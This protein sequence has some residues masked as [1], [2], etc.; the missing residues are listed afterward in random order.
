MINYKRYLCKTEWKE[1]FN[2][3]VKVLSYWCAD[4]DITNFVKRDKCKLYRKNKML[5][6][7]L[8]LKGLYRKKNDKHFKLN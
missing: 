3:N 4:K 8:E 2:Q 6:Q 5:T 7:T 1:L